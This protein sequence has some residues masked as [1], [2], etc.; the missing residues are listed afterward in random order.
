VA[1]ATANDEFPAYDWNHMLF[2]KRAQYSDVANTSEMQFD[3]YFFSKR[4]GGNLFVE[5]FD[6]IRELLRNSP[7]FPVDTSRVALMGASAGGFM[8][9]AMINHKTRLF[10]SDTEIAHATI[11]SAGSCSCFT[12]S[13]YVN[14]DC[15]VT[16][17]LRKAKKMKQCKT[18]LCDQYTAEDITNIETQCKTSDENPYWWQICPSEGLEPVFYGKHRP[19]HPTMLLIADL[20]D[21]DSKSFGVGGGQKTLAGVYYDSLQKSAYKNAKGYKHELLERKNTENLYYAGVKFTVDSLNPGSEP[22][23]LHAYGANRWVEKIMGLA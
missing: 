1:G 17:L 14:D 18:F 16:G 20:R 22:H 19:E 11:A 9:S 2:N 13:A 15:R 21:K 5:Q 8:V 10:G 6:R 12:L 7:Q 23:M 3:E 4:Q